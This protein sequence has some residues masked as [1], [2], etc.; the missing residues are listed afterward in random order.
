MATPRLGDGPHRI[1]QAQTTAAEELT[2]AP[3]AQLLGTLNTSHI[4]PAVDDDPPPWETSDGKWQKHNSN[5]R[6]YVTVPDSWE[7]RWL[8]PLLIDHI[9]TRDWRAVVTEK[10]KVS[11]K[12]GYEHM[13]SPEGYIRKGGGDTV[14]SL[15]LFYMPKSWVESRQRLKEQESAKRKA[16]AVS[17]AAETAERVSTGQYGPYVHASIK[18]PT[19]TQAEGKSMTD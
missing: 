3:A 11:I 9:G 18:H 15:I 17:R 1:H 14:K 8:N 2:T 7:L 19:H 12:R 13:V 16:A 5:A 6:Q 4:K 10:G